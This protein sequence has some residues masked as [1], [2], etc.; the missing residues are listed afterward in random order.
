MIPPF[1]RRPAP[2]PNFYP[3]FSVFQIPPP[4]SEEGRGKGLNYGDICQ[5]SNPEKVSPRVWC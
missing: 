3:L 4:P 1:L 2:A 5:L